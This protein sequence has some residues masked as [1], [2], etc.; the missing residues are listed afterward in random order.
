MVIPDPYQTIEQSR[1]N[2]S[3]T[4]RFAYITDI[5]LSVCKP[6]T[7]SHTYESILTD[8]SKKSISHAPR[9]KHCDVNVNT[10]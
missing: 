4:D 5:A 2:S 9:A 1:V 10:Q 3:F 7:C 6:A 8:L